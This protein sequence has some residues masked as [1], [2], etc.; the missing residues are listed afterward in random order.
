[1]ECILLHGLGQSPADWKDTVNYIDKKYEVSCPALFEWLRG[2]ACC[3]TNLYQGLEQYCDQFEEPFVLVGLSLGGI[4][5]MQYAIEHSNKVD[6]LILIGT[7]YFMPK[8]MLKFQNIIF[9]LL[10][11]RAFTEMGASKKEMI[12]LCRSMMNLDFTEKLK[13]IRSRTLI[14]CGEKDR[15]NYAAS[16]KLKERIPNAELSVVSGAGH[17]INKDKPKQLGE[18]IDAFLLE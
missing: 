14:L 7:Q 9:R 12:R 11:D 18:R 6:A 17:E 3:Y 13:D 2:K 1:M 8:R 5:A 4:L 10:P 16:I 15:A